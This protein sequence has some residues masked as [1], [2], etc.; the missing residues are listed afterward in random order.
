MSRTDK[1]EA[2]TVAGSVIAHLESQG[3]DVL[4][5]SETAI[6]LEISKG[7]S[8]LG[9]M[10]SDFIVIIGGD[11][12]ILRAAMLLMDPETP[13]LGVNLGRRGFLT[14]VPP[15]SVQQAL[16][17]VLKGRYHLEESVKLSSRCNELE[18]TFPDSLNEVL[19]ASTLPSKVLDVSLSVDDEHIIDIQAD[20][21]LVA[22][23]TG[24]TAYN[25][26]AGGS[27]LAPELPAMILTAVSPYSYFRSII[28]PLSSRIKI[29]MLKPKADALAIIDGRVF[30]ALKPTS[31][32]EV[33]A[34][35]HKARFIRFRSF[36]KRLKRRLIFQHD[37]HP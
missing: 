8:E 16:E 26:S 15:N 33:W 9:E 22:T 11:G 29:G 14:E 28:T 3:V 37:L 7:N 1:P 21:V 12:T 25:L 17:R 35:P 6:A 36:Y 34:S 5:E 2:L 31:I 32:I 20:G 13:I 23:P 27:I 4:V 19:V 18:E 24:S 30:A 10:D